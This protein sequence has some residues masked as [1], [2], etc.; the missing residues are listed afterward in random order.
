MIAMN[1]LL[2]MIGTLGIV[3]SLSNAGFP[4]EPAR[5]SLSG[6]IT[7]IGAVAYSPAAVTI[8]EGLTGYLTKNGLPSDYVLYSNY[9][10]LVVALQRREIDIAWNTPLAHAKFH[11]QNQCSSQTLV[12]RDVDVG[13]RSVVVA[14]ADSGIKSP[15]DLAGKR[16]VLGSSQAAEATVLPL[17]FLKKEGFDLSKVKVVSL[18]GEV[19]SQ[20]NPCDSPQHVLQALRSGRGDAGIITAALW[21]RVK[22]E[23]LARGALQH[24]WISP[25]F[26]HCVFTAAATFDQS[27][28][29]QFTKLMLEMDPNDRATMD[30]MRLEGTKKWVVGTAEGFNDLVDALREK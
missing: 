25:R 22:Q 6:Q 20:G 30:V 29:S 28:A 7:R 18:D 9:D 27:R 23:P 15:E 19:D 8:F 13:V 12:M 1:T 26:S 14:L 17:L 4:D 24:V 10:S 3:L 2:R 16:L 5:E 21:N 11:V